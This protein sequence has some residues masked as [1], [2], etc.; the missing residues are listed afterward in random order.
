MNIQVQMLAIFKLERIK[1]SL[2]ECPIGLALVFVHVWQLG[3]L[4]SPQMCCNQDIHQQIRIWVPRQGG[5]LPIRQLVRS[6]LRIAP[7]D[8]HLPPP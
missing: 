7:D 8:A 4:D 1:Q 5:V 2:N 6:I 3:I